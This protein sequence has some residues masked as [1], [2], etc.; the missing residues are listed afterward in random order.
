MGARLAA[1]RTAADGGGSLPGGILGG[2]LG[3][4]PV[5]RA[6]R[7]IRRVCDTCSRCAD[8]RDPVSLAV[9]RGCAAPARSWNRN[10]PSPCDGADGHPEVAGPDHPGAVA[11]AA[12]AD[13]G[14]DQAHPRRSA[15]TASCA[16]RSLGAARA[17][18]RLDGCDLH[19][20]RQRSPRACCRG[21]RL[22]RHFFRG[23]CSPRCM[24]DTAALHQPSADHPVELLEQGC[25]ADRDGAC[26][27]SGGKHADRPFQRRQAGRFRR[28]R[29]DGSPGGSERAARHQRAALHHCRRRHGA[30]P[31]ALGPAAMDVQGDARSSAEYFARQ[32]SRTAGEG[33]AAALLQA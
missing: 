10:S 26:L 30:C 17:G 7:C 8:S 3:H 24:G 22:G 21:V 28:R 1:P 4:F 11:G 27:G 33:R 25:S 18:C 5:L 29:R 32:G 13:A 15:V 2:S 12:C 16:S 9:A 14:V 6:R 23:E 19:R 31:L 20:R